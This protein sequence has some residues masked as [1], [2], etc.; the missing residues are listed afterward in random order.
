MP[1]STSQPTVEELA[2]MYSDEITRALDAQ[3]LPAVKE[4]TAKL[5]QLPLQIPGENAPPAAASPLAKK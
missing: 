2:K 5:N 4:A 3:Y 1:E